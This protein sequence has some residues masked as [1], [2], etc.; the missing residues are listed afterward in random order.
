MLY[1]SYP[2]VIFV[3]VF[4]VEKE[5]LSYPEYVLI[6]CCRSL[7]VLNASSTGFGSR[8][9]SLYTPS[10]APS[11]GIG[12]SLR[13]RFSPSTTACRCHSHADTVYPEDLTS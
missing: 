4:S 12:L 10:A 6:H 1:G 11:S 8:T 13:P 2:K 3:N 7:P 5:I 9:A